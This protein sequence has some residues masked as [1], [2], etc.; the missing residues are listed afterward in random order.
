MFDV[1]V[2]NNVCGTNGGRRES[3]CCSTG[4][5][6]LSDSEVIP[7]W[8]VRTMSLCFAGVLRFLFSCFPMSSIFQ[9]KDEPTDIGKAAN[10]EIENGIR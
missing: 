2:L 10:C 8:S 3:E 5:K 1:A 6:P 4:G 7:I 9:L